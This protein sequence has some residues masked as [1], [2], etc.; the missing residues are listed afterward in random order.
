MKSTFSIKVIATCGVL[1]AGFWSG[2]A[3]GAKGSFQESLSVDEPIFLDVS[4]GSGTITI[5]TGSSRRV[6][7]T[8]HINVKRGSFL[9]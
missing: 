9:G 1:L 5:T 8:G 4:T 3:M 2:E 6:E 7:I